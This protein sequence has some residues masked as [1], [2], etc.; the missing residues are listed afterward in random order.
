M[1]DYNLW[2]NERLFDLCRSI[3]DAERKSDKAAFFGSI[4]GT[5]NHILYGDLAFMSRFTG[6][7]AVVPELGVDLYDDFDDLWQSRSSLDN[8][9]CE[10]SS[11]LTAGWLEEE[12]TYT[13]KVDGIT[14][15]IPK[16][17]LV[18]HMLNHQT[19]HRGQITTILSQMALDVGTTDIPFMPQ[20]QS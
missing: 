20:F 10:W 9:I 18:V 17:V 19:H 1:T 14:R 3:D 8:R 5:L 15:T 2:M 11:T 7:P 16:W 4:H 6:I 13:S 12:L